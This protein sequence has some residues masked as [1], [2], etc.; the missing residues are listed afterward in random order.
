MMTTWQLIYPNALVVLS[1]FHVSRQP[2]YC[3]QIRSTL[4]TC[5]FITK[6][7]SNQLIF[8]KLL[9]VNFELINHYAGGDTEVLMEIKRIYHF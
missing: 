7:N 6:F 1:F 8:L 3:L 5:I 9:S 2:K 4:S